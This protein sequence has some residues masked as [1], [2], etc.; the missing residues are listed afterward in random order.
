[1]ILAEALPECYVFP[2]VS[3]NALITHA[4]WI[5]HQHLQRA[6]RQ[7]FNTKYVDFVLCRKADLEVVAVVEFD[8][9]HHS[10][11]DDEQR[12]RLLADAGYRVERFKG[13]V[14]SDMVKARFVDLRPAIVAHSQ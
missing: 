7:K 3:F 6:V 8:G 4:S 13:R 10:N 1:M 11:H 14:T 12:D 5:R 2:Q 9:T